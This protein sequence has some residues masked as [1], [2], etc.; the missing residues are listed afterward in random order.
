M[1]MNQ[2]RIIRIYRNRSRHLTRE[3]CEKIMEYAN[4]LERFTKL[5]KEVL[6]EL[7]P[8]TEEEKLEA[9]RIEEQGAAF[10]E[11]E[12]NNEVVENDNVIEAEVQE[13]KEDNNQ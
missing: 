11:I 3:A 8:V 6:E 5:A 9:Q 1:L 7:G 12:E 4:D 13:V 10:Y 2:Y